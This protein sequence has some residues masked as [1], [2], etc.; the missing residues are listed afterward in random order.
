MQKNIRYNQ[1]NTVVFQD[2]SDD[3]GNNMDTPKTPSSANN[4]VFTNYNIKRNDSLEII[5]DCAED[6]EED[7]Y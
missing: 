7:Q 6:L 2:F 1:K 3:E 4:T 5:E